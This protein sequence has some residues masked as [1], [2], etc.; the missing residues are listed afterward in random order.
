MNRY[1]T[2]DNKRLDIDTP[3]QN[4]RKRK[5][6]VCYYKLVIVVYYSNIN[7]GELKRRRCTG[8]GFHITDSGNWVITASEVQETLN[9]V[10]Q[11]VHAIASVPLYVPSVLNRLYNRTEHV[12][13]LLPFLTL[14]HIS[15][16]KYV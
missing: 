12:N 15:S 1:T 5:P 2:E 6:N 9:D 10:F 16:V 11:C 8:A 7:C 13:E 3:C 14:K 4:S